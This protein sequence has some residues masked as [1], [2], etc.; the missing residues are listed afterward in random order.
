MGLPGGWLSYIET[1][2]RYKG[3]EGKEF[4]PTV[5]GSRTIVSYYGMLLIRSSRANK[6]RESE[7]GINPW[8]CFSAFCELVLIWGTFALKPDQCVDFKMH[9]FLVIA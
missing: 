1:T 3:E 8:H 2:E 6:E 4:N 9:I 5:I 7:A